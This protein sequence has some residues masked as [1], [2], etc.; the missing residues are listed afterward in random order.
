MTIAA[1]ILSV[2]LILWFNKSVKNT[3]IQKSHI[4]HIV[5]TLDVFRFFCFIS[6]HYCDL[7][8]WEESDPI[9]LSALA[10]PRQTVQKNLKKQ[11]TKK[12]WAGTQC[13]QM[14]TRFLARG[15]GEG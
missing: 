1:F 7:L 13:L 4:T 2:D 14:S 3:T 5:H 6:G 12:I 10:F 11:H 15:K 8:E 9:A